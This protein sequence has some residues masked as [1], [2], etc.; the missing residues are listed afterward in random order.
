MLAVS[1]L[2]LMADG[3]H[4]YEAMRRVVVVQRDEPRLS[5]RNH[6]LA[7]TLVRAP[8]SLRATCKLV[9]VGSDVRYDS[10]RQHRIFAGVELEDAYEVGFSP[11]GES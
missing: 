9:Q 10:G 8:A 7:K 6:K 11:R 5:E 2:S 3:S 4:V 1:S